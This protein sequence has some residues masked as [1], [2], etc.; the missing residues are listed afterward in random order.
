MDIRK[1]W[2]I[3]L[4]CFIG[5]ASCLDLGFT[6]L[7]LNISDRFYEANP[8][9]NYGF[10]NYGYFWTSI[11]KLVMTVFQCWG[12]WF[13]IVYGK[14]IAVKVLSIATLVAYGLLGTWWAICWT[15]FF[16]I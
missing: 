16:L 9:M 12:S 1:N 8:V 11:F 3:V 4:P 6:L 15:I 13:V 7:L 14:R 2:H 5:L 10:V